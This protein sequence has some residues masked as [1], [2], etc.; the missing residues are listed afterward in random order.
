M[1]A[2]SLQSL[3]DKFPYFL[4]KNEGS[5]F[6]KVQW[7]NNESLK[8]M[9]ND[10]FQVY[11]SFHLNKRLL[12]WKEQVEKYNYN[13]HFVANYPHLKRVSITK[14]DNLIYMEEYSLEEDKSQFEF[15]YTCSYVK[16]NIPEVNVFKC[17]DCEE[18][19]FS[20]DNLTVCTTCSGETLTKTNVYQCND[21]DEIY[22]SD[23]TPSICTGCNNN[24]NF[25]KINAYKCNHCGQVYLGENPPETCTICGIIGEIGINNLTAYTGEDLSIRDN[26][27][28]FPE[29][30]TQSTDEVISLY[31]INENIITE[32]PSAGSDEVF[33]DEASDVEEEVLYNEQL[34]L[35]VPVIPSDLFLIKVETYDEYTL[36][37]GYP[38]RDITYDTFKQD[39][40]QKIRT[41]YSKD[42]DSESVD[43]FNAFFHDYSLDEFGA[44]ND[45]PRKN[46]IDVSNPDLYSLTEPPFNNNLTEDDY[47]YMKRILEYNL[48][49]WDTPAP[50]LEIWKLYGLPAV[51]LNRDRLL[52]KMFD[53]THHPF[54]E[55][56][57]LVEC[58]YPEEWEHK[59]RFCDGST[60][61]GEYFFVELDTI[62]PVTYQNIIFTFKILNSLA[63]E[64]TDDYKV[65]IYH[66]LEDEGV[67]TKKLLKKDYKDNTGIIS[68]T[69][70]DDETVNVLR[71]E[72]FKSNGDELGVEEI[73]VNVRN[74]DDGDWYVS[75]TGDDITGDGSKDNPF[76]TL[77]KALSVVNNALDLIVIEGDLEFDNKDSIPVINANCIIMGCDDA[78]ITSNY[79]RQFFHLVGERNISVHLI[80]LTLRNDEIITRI[81]S[82]EYLN[83]NPNFYDYETVIIHGGATVLETVIDK[84]SYYPYDYV[85]VKGVLKT[86]EDILLKNKPLV[87]LLNDEE[88]AEI[89][90]DD[91]GEFDEW[92]R[93]DTFYTSGDSVLSVKFDTSN[94]FENTVD[95]NFT[96]IQPENIRSRYGQLVSLNSLDCSEPVT[97]YY[98][99]DKVIDTVTPS[100]D[101]V[102]C[103]KFTP[104]WGT[105]TVY[106]Y[107]G[108]NPG[109]VK[110]EWIVDTYLNIDDLDNKTFVSDIIFEDNGEF[111]LNR[112]TIH[113]L[114]DLDGLLT[115]IHMG[116]DL[117]YDLLYTSLNRDDYTDDEWE[118][119]DLTPTEFKILK[120][121][122][123]DITVNDDGDLIITKD[124]GE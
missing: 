23:N 111:R 115:D 74:C 56:T 39:N 51:M 84:D 70:L 30:E 96:L 28:D 61:L 21:C 40:P 25:T 41:V 83:N 53:E 121:V 117:R 15:T 63:E 58:W 49:M 95:F 106:T 91:E 122:I 82:N 119:S 65:D 60:S 5:N 18:I 37:K 72:A 20:N 19:Y 45:I 87:I 77:P 101:G 66:Y 16:E 13:I 47:H 31:D 102:A 32:Y 78:V 42:D 108:N 89:T 112:K 44:L 11:E 104:E 1:V 120:N 3:L 85:N 29:T 94:Y 81:K 79:Q 62:R 100:E 67:E 26:A 54:D 4:N 14:N 80:N 27:M 109:S 73:L 110:D 33:I 8:L 36:L 76:K 75:K 105:T 10:L 99:D 103:L 55:Q 6:Y 68:Y 90:T 107:S 17:D 35:P 46:Y 22:F 2:N 124:N 43:E 48:R 114:S 86:K 64:I 57:G 97:F 50:V 9:Y 52:I 118:G 59:D 12:V 34:R 71:F 123:V 116:D 38:E 88:I 24:H 98:K 7:V 93:I 113:K 69:D 92:I